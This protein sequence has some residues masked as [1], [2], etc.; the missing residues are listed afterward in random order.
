MQLNY[1][2]KDMVKPEVLSDFITSHKIFGGKTPFDQ[3]NQ[4]D[5]KDDKTF[6]VPSQDSSGT[7]EVVLSDETWALN[8]KFADGKFGKFGI[9]NLE[10]NEIALECIDS[11]PELEWIKDS[12]L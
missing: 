9:S 8:L 6:A 11:S 12:K 10:D 3:K 5:F 4:V 7:W 2:P 1:F